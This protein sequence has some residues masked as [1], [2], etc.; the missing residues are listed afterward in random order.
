MAEWCFTQQFLDTVAQSNAGTSMATAYSEIYQRIIIPSQEE[1][2]GGFV[3][4][5]ENWWLF[6]IYIVEAQLLIKNTTTT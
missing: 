4:V 1:G 2:K 6:Q 5:K 3:A